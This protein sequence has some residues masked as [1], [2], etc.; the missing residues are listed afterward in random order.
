MNTTE[1]HRK[2]VQLQQILRTFDKVAVAFSGGID[3]TFLLYAACD[4][5]GKDRVLAM[6][7]VSCLLATSSIH[8][9]TEI[10]E[11]YFSHKA[12]FR[13]IE[14]EPLLW[15]EFAANTGDRCYF[16]KK[17]TYS[18]FKKEMEK[19]GC[20]FLLDGTNVDD[21]KAHR[22]GLRAVGEL[23]VQTPLV[24][25]GFAKQEIRDMAESI[26]LANYDQPSNSC[27]ATR[28]WTG[29]QIRPRILRLIDDAEHFL[30]E[31]GFLGCRV[32]PGS[33]WTVIEVRTDDLERIT[34]RAN[35]EPILQYF[36]S[37]GFARVVIDLHG[38]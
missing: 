12:E 23:G 27:L 37:V 29:V 15:D 3:S 36:A 21:L 28:V 10:F 16:C 8:Q 20:L 32:R 7:G 24:Q 13:Q 6:Q 9:A 35:R 31:K 38:R 30:H 34:L 4:T 25:A 5:L 1:I 11:R 14:L 18:I 2:Y 22:P 17:R 33:D 19:D 26:G